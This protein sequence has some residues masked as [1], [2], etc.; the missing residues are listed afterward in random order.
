MKNISNQSYAFSINYSFQTKLYFMKKI[1][2]LILSLI[3]FGTMMAQNNAER[4]QHVNNNP[5]A[6]TDIQWDILW[7]FNASAGSQAGIE[8]DGNHVY[9]PTW[10]STTITRYD[11]DGANPTDFTIAGVTGLRD[12]AYDGTYFYGASATMALK[13]MDFT[14]ETLVAS[15]NASCAGV[16]GIR[17]IAYDPTLDGG[18]GGFWIGNWAELGAINMEGTQLIA[19]QGN[20]S[21]YGSAY[22]DTDPDN[23]VLWCFQQAGLEAVTFQQF[24]INTLSFTGVNHEASDIPGFLTGSIAGGACTWDDPVSGIKMLIGNIQQTPN[25]IFAYELSGGT[26]AFTYD[27]QLME[28]DMPMLAELN[29]EIQVM[30]KVK[31]RGSE[32]V[33]SFDVSYT[34]D[35]GSPIVSTISGVS[36]ATSGLYDFVSDQPLV[37]D[38]E[39][40]YE[41]VVTIENINGNIDEDPSNNTLTHFIG[42]V[43]FVPEKKVFGEEATGTWCGWCPRGTV[44]MDYMAATYP[45]TWIGV[46]VHNGDPMVNTVYDNGIAPHI[47]GYPNA[48]VDRAVGAINPAD[49]EDH[50]LV[51]MEAITPA[52]L[53]LSTI[54][55][56]EETREI[57]FDVISEF[58]VDINSELRF[59]AVI[60]ED[61]L[62]GT[63]SGW[64]QA[65]SYSG[66]GNGPMGGFELLA[67][68]VPAADM[69]YDH[70]AREILGGWDGTANSLPATITAGSTHFYT[71]TYTI[72]DAMRTDKMTIIGLL[73]DQASGEVLNANS[74]DMTMITGI[75]EVADFD[76]IVYPNP[77]SGIVNVV[78]ENKK[79]QAVSIKVY[80]LMGKVMLSREAQMLSSGNQQVQLDVDN[81]S[82]GLY[83]VEVSTGSTRKVHKVSVSN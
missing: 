66:G 9:C 69:H 70:V 45:D 57:S 53:E 80:D 7:T 13:V 10:N 20:E 82:D 31:N 68:P 22:D 12:L 44:A 71:Y 67:N 78:F 42:I 11:M 76:L 72:P 75:E 37:F 5:I 19:N 32:T 14:N 73:I 35:G 41:I 60:A 55:W 36:I 34:I 47:G 26:A 61:S 43:P 54:D 62:W 49:F 16:T 58:V 27:M 74:T 38:T 39:G 52:S 23:P 25:L 1:N 21:C 4:Y 40:S 30:G 79:N 59:N 50:Y 65:N 18:N 24:D 28:L 46:A 64:A 77:A 29:E 56:D 2:L 3:M 63:S 6:G 15:I 48:L 81:F 17:H 83:F 51:R 33:T 8:T